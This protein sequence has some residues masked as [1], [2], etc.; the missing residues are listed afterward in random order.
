MTGAVV[1]AYHDVGVVRRVT[2]GVALVR[3][4][5]TVPRVQC[6]VVAHR[7]EPM[8]RAVVFAYHDVGVCAGSRWAQPWC[9]HGAPHPGRIVLSLLKE[10]R[11]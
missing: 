5:R 1:F 6:A 8:T 9:G 3:T 4:R 2:V 10:R 7:M 11:R